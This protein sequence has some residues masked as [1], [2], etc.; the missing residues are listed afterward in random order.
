V[1]PEKGLAVF[2]KVLLVFIEHAI[3]PRKQFLGAVVCVQDDGNS[4]DGGDSTDVVGSSN[5]TGDTRCLVSVGNTLSCKSVDT[6]TDV[7]A[8]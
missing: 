4:I 1:I 5:S 7:P 8:K 2:F 6:S 3:E